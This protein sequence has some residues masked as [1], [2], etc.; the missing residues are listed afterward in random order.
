M[1]QSISNQEYQQ[2]T[3]RVRDMMSGKDIDV[4]FIYHDEYYMSNGFYLSN[5][6][7][8]IES[9]AVLLPLKGKTYLLGGPEA[10]TY[11]KEVSVIKE[12]RSAECFIV[13]EEEYPGSVIHS[14]EA[15]F[16]EAMQDNRLKTVGIVGYDQIPNGVMQILQ[17]SLEKLDPKIKIVDATRDY[18]LLRADKSQAEIA[19]IAE[20][21]ALGK[22]GLKAAIPLVVPGVSEYQIAGA[23]EGTMKSLSAD[24]FNFRSLVGSGFRSNGVVPPASGKIMREEDMVLI[25]LS[26]K[27]EGYSAGVGMTVPVG[28][29]TRDQL[30]FLNDMVDALELTRDALIPGTIGKD[31]DAVARTFLTEKGYGNYLSMGFVHTVGLNEYELPFFGP[32]SEDVL[33]ENMTVCIDI[34]MFNHPKFHGARYETGYVIR[35]DG[36]HPLCPELDE[37]IFSLRDPDGF[38]SQ[39]EK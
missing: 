3:K 17:H 25:G 10:E 32:N 19:A 5:Y 24:G 9:G 28:N 27:T 39:R 34:A 13:P 16:S 31:I 20:A 35:S 1:S 21:F 30:Q 6:W 38:W 7:P 12:N 11:A 15:L 8:I 22:E 36:A 14:M 33:Q 29:G 23:A 2:R 26:P 4:L 37:L 18:M